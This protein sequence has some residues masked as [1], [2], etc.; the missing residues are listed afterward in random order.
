MTIPQTL[1][2]E[3]CTLADMP[4]L[5]T[6]WFA[7]FTDPSLRRLWPDTPL[8]RAWWDKANTDDFVHRSDRQVFLKVVVHCSHSD[9][10]ISPRIAGYAKWDLCTPTQRGQ[11]YPDWCADM[12]A[13]ECETFFAREE[14][15][16]RRVMGDEEH[17]YLDTLAVHPAFQRRGVG[18]MLVRWGVERAEEDGVGVY[19]DASR[20]GKR[21]YEKCGFVDESIAGDGDGDVASMAI[22]RR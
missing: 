4:Q 22:H 12:P 1:T 9:T 10:S 5:S 20:D 19:L 14:A 17:Y 16:R 18:S 2:L 8:V 6:I 3:R 7:A 15:E 13:E 21:L 11:R